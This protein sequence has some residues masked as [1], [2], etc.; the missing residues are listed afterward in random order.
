MS[1][2]ARV[3]KAGEV[4]TLFRASAEHAARAAAAEEQRRAELAAAFAAGREEGFAAGTAQA[5]RAG[6]A[7]AERAATALVAAAD[8]VAAQHAAQ[9]DAMSQA[10]LSAATDI[11]RWV[12]R[13]E[14][15]DG[16]RSLLAR[17]DEAMAALLPSPSTRIAVSPAD[18][19]VVREW[20]ARRART[21]TEIVADARLAPGDA[22]VTTDAGLAEVTVP[23]ALR[24]AAAALGLSGDESSAEPA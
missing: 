11:A 1:S 16:G 2:E 8:T 24:A 14:L 5:E 10:V 20:A 22:V 4:H 13:R 15:S 6:V 23:A 21:G 18:E 9:V 17:L 7:A 12:L 3:L 19:A